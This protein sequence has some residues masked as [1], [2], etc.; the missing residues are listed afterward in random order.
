MALTTTPANRKEAWGRRVLALA[1]V[2]AVGFVLVR[3]VK[4][5]LSGPDEDERSRAGDDASRDA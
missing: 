2:T 4:A 5:G 1:V 3:L